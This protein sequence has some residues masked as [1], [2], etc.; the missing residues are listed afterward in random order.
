[1]EPMSGEEGWEREYV[2]VVSRAVKESNG[3]PNRAG[4]ITLQTIY[5]E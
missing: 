5:Q 4:M 2:M 3:E 1:M